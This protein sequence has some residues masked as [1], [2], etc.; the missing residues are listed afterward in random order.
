MVASDD[1]VPAKIQVSKLSYLA[2]V[3]A[4]L[5]LHS[6]QNYVLFFTS[7]FTLFH[8]RP[9]EQSEEDDERNASKN[10]FGAKKGS[11]ARGL[12]WEAMV[13]SLNEIPTEG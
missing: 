6:Y 8:S 5:I 1:Q 3:L 12:A 2:K 13:D 10:Y 4:A 7:R 11:P 9:M